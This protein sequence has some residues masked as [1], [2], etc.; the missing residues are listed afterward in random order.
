[1]CAQISNVSKKYIYIKQRTVIIYFEFTINIF[2]TENMGDGART[3]F[4]FIQ[5]NK[6]NTKKTVKNF[7]TNLLIS[8]IFISLFIIKIQFPS[9]KIKLLIFL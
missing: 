4:D 8:F 5:M 9:S 6:I 7:L 1:M 2:R 3:Y